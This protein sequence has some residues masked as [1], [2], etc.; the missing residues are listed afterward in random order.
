M[1]DKI[2][3]LMLSCG[4]IEEG[5]LE[6][7]EEIDPTDNTLW[8]VISIKGNPQKKLR[9]KKEYIAAYQIEELP[10]LQEKSIKIEQAEC[11]SKKNLGFNINAIRNKIYETNRARINGWQPNK[12]KDINQLKQEVANEYVESVYD[13]LPVSMLKKL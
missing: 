12:A 4:Q 1:N 5:V 10:N 7:W 13:P 3:R 9:I 6:N 2:I 8:A 11:I